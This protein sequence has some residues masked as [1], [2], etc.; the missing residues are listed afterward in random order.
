MISFLPPRQSW[1]RQPLIAIWRVSG[2]ELKWLLAVAVAIEWVSGAKR[3]D[4]LYEN[5]K[6]RMRHIADCLF[7]LG[8]LIF[9]AGSVLNFMAGR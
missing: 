1:Y 9:V 2:M 4:V 3:D 8:S 5:E 7:V 6:R